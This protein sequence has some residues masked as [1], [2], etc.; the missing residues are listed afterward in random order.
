MHVRFG[1]TEFVNFSVLQCFRGQGGTGSLSSGSFGKYGP[2][3][4]ETFH[5]TSPYPTYG[6]GKLLFLATFKADMWH[7][8]F[9]V[10]VFDYKIPQ[11]FFQNPLESTRS[12]ITT[13]GSWRGEY[14]G[15]FP[16]IMGVK[17]SILIG[18]SIINHPFW[19]YITLFLE[20]SIYIYIHTYM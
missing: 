8:S 15:V 14:I 19:G 20:T 3:K 4:L 13:Y 5:G 7:V 1:G 16:K 18:L 2:K 9:L 10:R 11:I 6:R 17:S 12:Q